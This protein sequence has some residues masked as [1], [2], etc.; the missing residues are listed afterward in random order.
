M[1]GGLLY[2]FYIKNPWLIRAVK[3]AEGVGR[4]LFENAKRIAQEA[5]YSFVQVKTG[6]RFSEAL[7]NLW[8]LLICN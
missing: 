8:V 4:V 7:F 5:G 1:A 6:L 2:I 3:T